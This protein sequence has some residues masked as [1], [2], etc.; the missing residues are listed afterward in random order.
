MPIK[1]CE[2]KSY[3]IE[4]PL[5]TR[6]W[7]SIDVISVVFFATTSVVTVAA[8]KDTE[9]EQRGAREGGFPR[10]WRKFSPLFYWLTSC[11]T[12][13][14]STGNLPRWIFR[15]AAAKGHVRERGRCR[16]PQRGSSVYL[17]PLASL[18]KPLTPCI[19]ASASRS[20]RLRVLVASLFL[21]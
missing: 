9:G 21:P 19:S 6:K 20:S 13:S 18:R 11:F 3:A 14:A 12:L 5:S 2:M 17:L 10:S 1:T 15:E 8:D 4:F 16:F 7:S